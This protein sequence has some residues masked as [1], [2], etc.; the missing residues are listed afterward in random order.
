MGSHCYL[1]P[2]T[3]EHTP[4][5]VYLCGLCLYVYYV[6]SVCVVV[7]LVFSRKFSWNSKYNM[8]YIDNPV[9]ISLTNI[10][11]VLCI[12]VHVHLCAG[13]PPTTTRCVF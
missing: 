7:V 12:N 8:L 10:S 9:S 3:S 1:S 2:D 11:C 13:S 6:V 4:V 5:Y